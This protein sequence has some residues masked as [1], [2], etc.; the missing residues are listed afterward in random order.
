MTADTIAAL[1]TSRGRGA[2]S[3]VRLSGPDS[4]FIA[5]KITQKERL[6]PRFATLSTL[7]D[8]TGAIIDEA[9][10]IYFA[11]PKSFTGEEIV[12]FQ[13]H[14]GDV[15]AMLLLD[16]LFALGARPAEAGEFTKR[17]FFNGKIDLTKAEAI[18]RL[19]D[20]KSKESARLL[21]K[22]L[23]GALK[24]FVDAQ[25]NELVR[26]LA[27]SEVM[28]DYADEELPDELLQNLEKSLLTLKESLQKTHE[29]SCNSDGF[30][31]GYKVAIIGKPNAGK[32]SLLNALL[33]YE[34]AIVSDV[35]GTTRDM[36]EETITMGSHTIRIVDTAGIRRS[37]DAIEAIGIGYSKK[38]IEE[39]DIIIVLFDSSRECDANDTEILSLVRS[40]EGQ[41]PIIAALN[42]SDLPHRFDATIL[43]GLEQ[44][45]I[46]CKGDVS[47]LKNA[48]A[49]LLDAMH[50]SSD[51]ILISKRQ[52]QRVEETV[53]A[54]DSAID[55]LKR[56]EL[57]IFSFYIN[58]AITA[59]S[60][61]SR[62]Y[63]H[64]QMLDEMFG[65]FC[66]GK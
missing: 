38:M 57:E 58:E 33:A 41:K 35:E 21:A 63:E 55:P 61:I 13:L 66:L 31:T 45:N 42:K 49:A 23:K 60:A 12:E 19:I 46:S 47:E 43:T 56:G 59:I 7:T 8:G 54:I 65:N 39:S 3:I 27:Y 14:G 5:L 29:A 25:R 40:V 2:I 6:E 30:F 17:A 36:I 11:S 28:I 4:L 62:P 64:A 1:A 37:R 16:E 24:V 15:V 9:L 20:A 18:A 32:S 51:Q 26:I 50:D 22:Q 52:I 48:I 34:R 44:I 53:S 10:V